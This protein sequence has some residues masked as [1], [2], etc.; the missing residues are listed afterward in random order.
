[1]RKVDE[2][3]YEN[4]WE[5]YRQY[6][7]HDLPWR[8]TNDPYHIL[9]SEVMLQQTQVDRVIPKYLAFLEMFPNIQTLAASS[10]ASVLTMW[11][12]LGYN[13]RAKMLHACA[14]ML[15]RDFHSVI[16]D[17]EKT[18]RSLPGIGP[19]TARAIMAF[20]F[21]Q[22]L[23]LI[24]TNI[25]TVYIY[26]YFTDATDVSDADLWPHIERTLVVER[27][28][29]WYYALMDYGSYL[30]RTHGNNISK[31]K[32]YT[33]QVAFQGSD[34]QIRGAIIRLLTTEKSMSRAR[35][36]TRLNFDELRIDAQL[37]RLIIEQLVTKIGHRYTLPN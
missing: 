34:R 12:G 15:S 29:E 2:Q 6:G 37:E 13:R 20:A 4:V 8:Q 17:D 10:L 25:R 24:E 22:A 9:V 7:R 23:P 18:L 3:L 28:R 35:L 32:H 21:N 27:P 31:S 11:Q 26:H 5:F 14:Q 36:L 19:Y 16:P 1:M 30:K 33:K